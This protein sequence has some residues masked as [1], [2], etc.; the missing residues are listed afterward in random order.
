MDIVCS[1]RRNEHQIVCYNVFA[2]IAK[3]QPIGL[4]PVH[5]FLRRGKKYVHGRALLDLVL[6]CTGA[7]IIERNFCPR[8]VPFV[9]A[10]ELVEHILQANRC[11]HGDRSLL[12]WRG[13]RCKRRQPC[14][15]YQKNNSGPQPAGFLLTVVSPKNSRHQQAPFRHLQSIFTAAVESAWHP[16]PGSN[17]EL[18]ILELESEQAP[19]SAPELGGLDPAAASA[20]AADI[21]LTFLAAR[22]SQLSGPSASLRPASRGPRPA[23]L[24]PSAVPRVIRK[25]W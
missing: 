14:R 22:R 23:F 24:S 12:G 13:L 15:G 9:F 8:I 21:R 6:Q 25:T 17:L 16:A 18:R 4:K 20:S 3:D 10:P 11:R 7:G 1:R 2:R 19:H 5:L